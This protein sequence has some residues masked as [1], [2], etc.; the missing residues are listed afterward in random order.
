MAI[1]TV[2][3]KLIVKAA[4]TTLSWGEELTVGAKI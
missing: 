3:A 1:R 4:M 2:E